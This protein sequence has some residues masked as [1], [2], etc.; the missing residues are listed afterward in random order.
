MTDSLY[1]RV[2]TIL[3]S[4]RQEMDR[5]VQELI[6][7]ESLDRSELGGCCPR[8]RSRVPDADILWN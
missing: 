1:G 6:R 3:V 5:I 7:K 4:R 2:K 8:P